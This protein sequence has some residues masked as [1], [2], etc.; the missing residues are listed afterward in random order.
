MR[1]F[2]HLRIGYAR[3]LF[4]FI[5]ASIPLFVTWSCKEGSLAT[6]FEDKSNNPSAEQGFLHFSNIKDYENLIS[7]S[8]KR[9]TSAFRAA[10]FTTDGFVAM[11]AKRS[12]ARVIANEKI[13]SDFLRQILNVDGVVQINKWII[14]VDPDRSECRVF[15]QEEYSAT[16]YKHLVEG[17]PNPKVYRFPDNYDVL[18][19][20]EAG[21]TS[22]PTTPPNG[23][24]ALFC[25]GG[26]SR[27]DPNKLSDLSFPH[28]YIDGNGDP[29]TRSVRFGARI[30]YDKYGIYFECDFFLENFYSHVPLPQINNTFEVKYTCNAYCRTNCRNYWEFSCNRVDSPLVLDESDHSG[31]VDSNGYN[32]MRERFYQ[33][34]RGLNCLRASITFKVLLKPS[35]TVSD[36]ITAEVLD[37]ACQP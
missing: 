30:N 1:F 7:L 17:V 8:A 11:R 12:S 23:R 25:G 6:I 9:D 19:L 32:F 24:V 29:Q 13:K 33:G 35:T 27:R 16:L 34:T 5:C 18:H 2:T 14:K 3:S 22:V 37:A 21:Y 20:L 36:V 31:A 28:T 4:F 15:F 26:I 10:L